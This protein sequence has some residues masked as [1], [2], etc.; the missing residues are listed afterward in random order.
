MGEDARAA[1]IPS[2]DWQLDVYAEASALNLKGY[3]PISIKFVGNNTAG[4]VFAVVYVTNSGVLQAQSTLVTDKTSQQLIDLV[5]A[6]GKTS[7][8][9]RCIA[10]DSYLDPG[11]QQKYAAIFIE[12]TGADFKNWMWYFNASTS[13]IKGELDQSKKTSP[14][15]LRPI[16]IGPNQQPVG[17]PYNYDVVAIHNGGADARWFWYDT[18]LTLDGVQTL[19]NKHADHTAR[20]YQL[21]CTKNPISDSHPWSAILVDGSTET[22]F[23]DEHLG[24]YND[25]SA[26]ISLAQKR[27][28]R[29]LD[30]AYNGDTNPPG[31]FGVTMLKCSP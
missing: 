24:Q 6:A 22:G 21:A 14:Y 15:P 7:K 13:F 25:G 9:L 29:V 26:I 27:V 18:T 5:N 1:L 3:R 11:V 31:Q 23:F 10:L 19:I 4:Q 17:V 8:P 12:N 28:A 20:V 16:H 30:V 2:S